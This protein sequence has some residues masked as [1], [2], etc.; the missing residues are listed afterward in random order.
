MKILYFRSVWGLE[1]P[2]IEAKLTRI[3]QGGFD[4]VEL[5]VPLDLETCRRA[6]QCLDDLGL[7]VVAQQWRTKGAT[8]AEHQRSFEEQYARALELRPLYLNSHTGCD[9]FTL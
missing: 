7:A 6:R 2:S 1:E 9:H 3:K 8:P 4:G 5:E